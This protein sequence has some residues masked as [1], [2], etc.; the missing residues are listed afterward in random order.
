MFKILN[1]LVKDE[2]YR[3]KEHYM[4]ILQSNLKISAF[5]MN[6]GDFIFRQDNKLKHLIKDLL[7]A[8]IPMTTSDMPFHFKHISLAFA[9]TFNKTE[10][11]S[12]E[13]YV[14]CSRAGKPLDLYVHAPDAYMYMYT[15]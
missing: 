2:K 4:S 1:M 8:R 10:G 15:I 7:L 6:L 9:M 12:L 11:Q 13:L 5:E 14:A 3:S